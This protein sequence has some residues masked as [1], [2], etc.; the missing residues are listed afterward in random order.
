MS[1]A[2]LPIRTVNLMGAPP[3]SWLHTISIGRSPA[4]FSFNN[5]LCYIIVIPWECQLKTVEF[6]YSLWW[7]IRREERFSETLR[8]GRDWSANGEES[9]SAS[10]SIDARHTARNGAT[11]GGAHDRLIHRTQA[12]CQRSRNT[13]HRSAVRDPWGCL[14][15][16]RAFLGRSRAR[17]CQL[18]EHPED[19][20]RHSQAHRTDEDAEQA[21]RREPAEDAE[22]DDQRVQLAS[23]PHEQGLQDVV[24][25]ERGEHR[26]PH[27]QE[28][29]G[30]AAPPEP[31]PD[32]SLT[33]ARY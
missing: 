11:G 31:Q 26:P 10:A 23:A 2:W 29:R 4:Y 27:S 18:A 16:V 19:H 21:K 25:D 1:S 5:R 15:S 33:V 28:N 32:P 12:E 22:Q 17:R 8:F 6:V 3:Y 9:D 20:Q 30:A 14:P 7:S 24:G 13:L